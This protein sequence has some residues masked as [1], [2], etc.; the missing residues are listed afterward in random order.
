MNNYTT[1]Q[2]LDWIIEEIHELTEHPELLV[3]KDAMTFIGGLNKAIEI[4]ESYKDE[5]ED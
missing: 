4:V 1:E 5:P 2:I 3:G